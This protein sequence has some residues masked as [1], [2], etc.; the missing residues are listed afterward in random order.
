[1]VHGFRVWWITAI[2]LIANA[3]ISLHLFHGG[4]SLFQ[5]LGL[6]HPSYTPRIRVGAAALAAF[7]GVGNISIPLLILARFVGSDVP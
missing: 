7:V 6:H 1:M 3:M 4:Q 2:Y 5:S